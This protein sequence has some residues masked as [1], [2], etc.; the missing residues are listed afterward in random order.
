MESTKLQFGQF[1][2]I[3][4]SNFDQN[5]IDLYRNR[6]FD[7]DAEIKKNKISHNHVG[8]NKDM[9]YVNNFEDSSNLILSSPSDPNY[10]KLSENEKLEK[11]IL[12]NVDHFVYSFKGILFFTFFTY[13]A[14]NQFNKI[15][16]PSGLFLRAQQKHSLFKYLS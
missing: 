15:Y 9:K 7:E 6:D 1:K 10:Y 11:G 16:S 2:D 12:T 3:D 13:F 8:L 14:I 4:E 5:V